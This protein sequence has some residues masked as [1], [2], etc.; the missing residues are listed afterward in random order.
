MDK[1]TVGIVVPIHPHTAIL[2]KRTNL[3]KQVLLSIR[4]QK[5]DNWN[6]YFICDR[7][8][9]VGKILNSVFGPNDSRIEIIFHEY[10]GKF[11]KNNKIRKFVRMVD[12]G[13]VPDCEWVCRLDDDDLFSTEILHYLWGRHF[14]KGRNID[15]IR[16]AQHLLFDTVGK[17]FVQK[18]VP[19]TANTCIMKYDVIKNHFHGLHSKFAYVIP[20]WRW[21][22]MPPDIPIFCRVLHSKSY[23]GDML[24]KGQLSPPFN[25][26]T[27]PPVG[28]ISY[29]GVYKL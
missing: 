9:E 16:D 20:T 29:E 12:D 27:E 5:Y 17:V 1:P 24:G 19:K 4:D 18:D 13:M 6:A 26:L 15:G 11:N 2:E 7:V 28:F 22:I 3:F 10:R 14:Y 23:T 21:V 8:L 25:T